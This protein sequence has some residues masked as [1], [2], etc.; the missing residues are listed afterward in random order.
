MLTAHQVYLCRFRTF[1]LS[2]KFLE[3]GINKTKIDTWVPCNVVIFGG[4]SVTFLIRGWNMY[5]LSLYYF[6]NVVLYLFLF[7]I[8]YGILGSSGVCTRM[9]FIQILFGHLLALQLSVMFIVVEEIFRL[10][11]F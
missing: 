9:L 4:L 6:N 8:D 3:I 1:S 11:V 10:V 7:L 2:S 5:T